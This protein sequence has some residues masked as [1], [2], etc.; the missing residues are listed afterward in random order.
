[1]FNT[2]RCIKPVIEVI[3]GKK[4]LIIRRYCRIRR[5]KVFSLAEAIGTKNKQIHEVKDINAF[6]HDPYY[7]EL[8][9]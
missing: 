7:V 3:K 4:N 9:L 6:K 2:R 8:G 1:M 5:K